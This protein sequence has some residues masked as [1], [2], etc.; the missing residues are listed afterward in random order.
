MRLRLGYEK[1]NLI[2]ILQGNARYWPETKEAHMNQPPIRR[3][4]ICLSSGLTALALFAVGYTTSNSLEFVFAADESSVAGSKLSSA[5]KAPDSVKP[6]LPESIDEVRQQPSGEVKLTT[7]PADA[8]VKSSTVDPE[9]L[10]ED[11]NLQV[12]E[13]SAYCLRGRTASGIVTRRGIIA[14]DPRVLP[15]GTIV[16]I[17]AGRYTG[18]YTVQDTGGQIKG[19]KVDIYIP[20]HQEALLFGRR[21][22]KLKVL[23]IPANFSSSDTNQLAASG[24]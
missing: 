18:I 24:N 15:L 9:E 2:V 1:K 14:A 13:A 12:Y 3:F 5:E 17:K 10:G 23:G 21:P 16:Q 20:S 6:A 19:K 7:P 4:K 11:I 8:D 22:I